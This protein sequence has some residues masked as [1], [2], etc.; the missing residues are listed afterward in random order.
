MSSIIHI[1]LPKI[2][3]VLKN[4]NLCPAGALENLLFTSNSAFP[5]ENYNFGATVL[6]QYF[7]L[8]SFDIL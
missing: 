4:D 8:T 1:N 6:Q 7:S 5:G 2:V 3:A